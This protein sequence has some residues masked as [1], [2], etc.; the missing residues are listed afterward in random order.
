[1]KLRNLAGSKQELAATFLR[2]L[3]AEASSGVTDWN[4]MLDAVDGEDGASTAGGDAEGVTVG[5]LGDADAFGFVV[6]VNK[7]T[8]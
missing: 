1:M 6:P 8:S 5:M 3:K 4:L 2:Q 7:S